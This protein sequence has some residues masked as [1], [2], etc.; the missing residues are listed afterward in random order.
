MY[1][2][3]GMSERITA[4]RLYTERL[5]LTDICE[6]YAPF[7]VKCRSDPKVY[8]FFVFPHKITLEEHLKWFHNTYVY[9]E[10]RYDW[11]ALY[12]NEPI[13][14]FGVKRADSCSYLA[15]ISYILVPDQHG[16]GFAKEAVIRLL[17]FSKN[18]WNCNIIVA[19]IHKN[20]IPSI[21]FIER[22]G[23]DKQSENRN[24]IRYI[25]RI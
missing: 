2:D 12:K 10:N 21:K 17:E 20:N 23:F 5:T 3:F 1:G 22:L 8:P 4:P 11:I 24:F 14:I 7:I 15:E 16:K 13:G 25:K 18:I 9:D 19:E 6:D